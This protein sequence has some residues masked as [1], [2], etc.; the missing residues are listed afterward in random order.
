MIILRPGNVTGRTE[1]RRLRKWRSVEAGS[2][3]GNLPTVRGARHCSSCAV[4]RRARLGK[5]PT[6]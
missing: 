3:V 6:V 4:W 5:L 1:R 2:T